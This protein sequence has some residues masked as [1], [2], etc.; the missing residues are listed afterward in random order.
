MGES[1]S[2]V[3]FAVEP[4]SINHQFQGGYDWDGVASEGWSK[5]LSTCQSGRHMERDTVQSN[6]MIEPKAKILYTYDVVWKKSDVAWSSRWDIYLT[7]DHLVPAQVHW[8]LILLRSIW[9][10][11]RICQ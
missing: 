6:M 11:S 8:Y 7:E 10:P 1:Y 5:Q 4:I 9:N 2:V 3:G